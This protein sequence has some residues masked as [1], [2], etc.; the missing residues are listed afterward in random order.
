M[1]RWTSRRVAST[2]T[3]EGAYAILYAILVV[4]ILSFAAM[5][6]DLGQ[7]RE[8]RRS[9]RALADNAALAGADYLSTQTG[10]K[11]KTACI[12]VLNYLASQWGAPTPSTASC[13]SAYGPYE[14]FTTCTPVP[15]PAAFTPVTIAGHSVTV[16]WPVPDGSPYMTS[17]D[18]KPGNIDQSTIN[19]A[20]D[21]TNPCTR[22]A[23]QIAMRQGFSFAT[24]FGAS[25]VVLSD[26]SVA[27]NNLHPG[28]PKNVAALNVL[29]LHTCDAL[30]TSG[31]GEILVDKT[32]DSSTNT[33]GPGIIAVESDGHP[34]S[35]SSTCPNNQPKVIDPN[36]NGASWICANGPGSG[37]T[38]HSGT[39]ALGAIVTCNG[40]GVI[41]SHA[42]DT[43]GNTA[44]AFDPS[45]V[46]ANLAP[47]ATPEGGVQG[48][49]PVTNDFG[50]ATSV[51]A[52]STP[53][54]QLVAAY[55]GSGQPA[56]TYAGVD[57]SWRN[58]SFQTLNDG[59]VLTTRTPAGIGTFKCI[60]GTF[61]VPPGNW[62]VNCPDKNKS[63]G[64]QALKSVFGGGTLV[65]A[66]SVQANNGDL[67]INV[68]LVS[69]L[70]G[71][72]TV[73]GTGSGITTTPAP[74]GDAVVYI[75]GTASTGG[76]ASAGSLS[77][78]GTYSLWAPQT[79]FYFGTTGP[80][81]MS[82]GANNGALVLT[83]PRAADCATTDAGCQNSAFKKL[84]TWSECSCTSASSSP[85]PQLLG[86]QGNV[87][88]LGV[89][90]TP[91]SEF[92]FQGQGRYASGAAQIWADTISMQ[93][94]GTIILQPDPAFAEGRSFSSSLLIR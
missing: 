43:G 35:A 29:N 69:T 65:F 31:Q 56:T 37:A 42:M 25:G 55:G 51:C 3:D 41:A 50:C 16:V 11:P 4:V 39:T 52:S 74:P 94:Q 93:G 8:D 60:G 7:A 18:V 54:R 2:R 78:S 57:N 34:T 68:P 47:A 24:V 85:G 49:A 90:F 71:T 67:A 89:F 76:N 45:R 73:S 63:P 53:I 48:V 59:D 13:D 61:Y 23:V 88:L 19:P 21:G 26:A 22:M 86:G 87:F 27:R 12:A 79:F 5:V 36:S 62:F 10:V 44:D 14:P 40:T 17:P 20:V 33:Y 84:V 81:F 66:G 83:S 91:Y 32:Y 82:F 80:G 28:G 70:T 30:T 38:I 72:I 77:G 64:F 58:A 92:D 6:V 46:T 75:R 9:D 1:I 15:T